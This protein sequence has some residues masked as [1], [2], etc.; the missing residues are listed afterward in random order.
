MKVLVL[1][2]NSE[3]L[4]DICM[5][6][7]QTITDSD[8]TE[9]KN[10]GK[11][12]AEINRH[13]F[14]LI[15]TDLLVPQFEDANDA[16]NITN[17]LL[18]E[19][20][21]VECD[22]YDTPVIAITAFNNLAE[23]NFGNLNKFDISVITYKQGCSEWSQSFSRKLKSSMPEE[24]FDFVIVCALE[25]EA[26]AYRE[27]GY[28]VGDVYTEKGIYC[29]NINISGHS[30][31]IVTPPRMG[32]VNAAILSA[33]SIDIFKPKLICM[34]GICAGIDGKANIYDVV[35]PDV[36]HQH[37]SGKWTTEGFIPEL[38]SIQIEHETKLKISEIISKSD[39]H[40]KVLEGIVPR[41]NEYPQDCDDLRC[42]VFLA[43]AS[44]G[45]AV[46]ADENMLSD[47][48]RQHRKCT[49]FEME[50]YALYEAARQSVD[51][52]T[53]FSAKS[54]V[55]NGNSQKGDDFQR[56]AC[57]LSARTVYEIL[58]RG[59]LR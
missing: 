24:S 8:V 53:Y 44:S 15:V 35:I 49:A 42:Q 4:N 7:R 10:F 9:T 52:I 26:D 55:D 17:L 54:V 59:L 40:S 33:R 31:V 51:P 28:E 41:K 56:L 39:F 50:S 45:S 21:D 25:K 11:F 43:P 37:D 38:Y 30:G 3:K 47:I 14:D 6:I 34:S 57:L 22:N 20:R 36:C 48:Q 13:K 32:L 23:E 1:E 5:L 19:V 46:V 16:V 12:V 27:A 18:S 58:S 2:D 29:R